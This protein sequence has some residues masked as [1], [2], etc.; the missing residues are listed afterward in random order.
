MRKKDWIMD[1]LII[2]AA[3]LLIL[4]I[5]S[6][7]GRVMRARAADEEAREIMDQAQARI[8]AYYASLPAQERPAEVPAS[9]AEPKV[10]VTLPETPEW[11]IEDIPLDKQLQR[12]AFDTANDNGVDYLLVLA[13]MSVESDFDSAAVSACGCY[14]LMQLNPRYFPVGLSDEDNIKAGTAY[15]GELL[16]KH[17]GDEPAA[18][19]AYNLGFDDGDRAYSSAVLSV[20]EEIMHKAGVV[21][22]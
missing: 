20:R 2:A 21:F 8:D 16:E 9:S 5:L 4:A 12:T 19:R 1:V 10:A 15:L 3:I 17:K 6:L 22:P 7:A 13:V 11:Y 14:G 18:L